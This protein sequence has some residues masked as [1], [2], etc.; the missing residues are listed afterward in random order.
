MVIV[1]TIL[2]QDEERYLRNMQA[3]NNTVF[4]SEIGKTA[5]ERK[6][7]LKEELRCNLSKRFKKHDQAR[8]KILE[9]GNRELLKAIRPK[10]AE[11]E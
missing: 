2:N 3:I 7:I 8:D 6:K 4:Q 1:N 10:L 5:A 11:T 9:N